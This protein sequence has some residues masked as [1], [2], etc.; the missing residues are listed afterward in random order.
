MI[1]CLL[2]H[3][4]EENAIFS[5]AF[6][7][8]AQID[9]ASGVCA[10]LFGSHFIKQQYKKKLWLPHVKRHRN[11]TADRCSQITLFIKFVP[12]LLLL[13]RLL[14]L[15]PDSLNVWRKRVF[16]NF[17]PTI[18]CEILNECLIRF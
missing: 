11:S 3:K 5:M 6:N 17:I 16:E 13:L 2:D 12:L 9:K 8:W 10:R 14:V 7:E 18:N 15:L 1:N 4:W